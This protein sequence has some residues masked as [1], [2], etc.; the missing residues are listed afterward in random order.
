MSEYK[1]KTKI[2]KEKKPKNGRNSQ[3]DTEKMAGCKHSNNIRIRCAIISPGKEKHYAM[4][5]ETKLKS[6]QQ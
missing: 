6:P 3:G 2:Y 1:Q 4:K 5:Q